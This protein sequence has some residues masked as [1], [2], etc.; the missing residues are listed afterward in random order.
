MYI[1]KAHPFTASKTEKE[2]KTQ[3]MRSD[4]RDRKRRHYSYI[5]D[6]PK[7]QIKCETG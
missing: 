5:G 7:N 6:I 3:M 1:G 4:K 2:D